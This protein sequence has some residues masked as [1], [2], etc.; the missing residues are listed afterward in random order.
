[1]LNLLMHFVDRA[2]EA[3]QEGATVEALAAVPVLRRLRRLGE[4]LEEGQ[5]EEAKKLWA[6]IDEEIAALREEENSDAG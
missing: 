1:M 6:D 5:P 3:L 4:E 2:R